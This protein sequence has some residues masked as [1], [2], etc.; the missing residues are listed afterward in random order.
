MIIP[1]KAEETEGRLVILRRLAV[2]FIAR[3]SEIIGSRV[4]GLAH[5]ASWRPGQ[6]DEDIATDALADGL[7]VVIAHN[8]KAT[9]QE[10]CCSRGLTAIKS[11]QYACALWHYAA[12]RSLVGRPWSGKRASYLSVAVR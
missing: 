3:A 2:V 4:N 7:R 5:K 8:L 9:V 1:V 10:M 11:K 6:S 12:A